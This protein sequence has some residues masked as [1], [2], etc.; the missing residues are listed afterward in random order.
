MCSRMWSQCLAKRRLVADVSTANASHHAP[1]AH[2]IAGSA[3][4][5]LD[6]VHLPAMTITT[7]L[8]R[9]FVALVDEVRAV[10]SSPGHIRVLG[11]PQPCAGTARDS[12]IVV[13]GAISAQTRL[14]ASPGVGDST[15]CS[16]ATSLGPRAHYTPQ[17]IFH[18][19]GTH[20]MVLQPQLQVVIL[21]APPP[22]VCAKAIDTADLLLADAQDAS[23]KILR[24]FNGNV[25]IM[26]LRGN[27]RGRS[28]MHANLTLFHCCKQMQQHPQSL[29]RTVPTMPDS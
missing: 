27:R 15:R 2:P 5:L 10:L 17:I 28:A 14:A 21:P 6:T 29:A 19:Q 3:G 4:A 18:P 13:Q 20:T 22:E 9:L 16:Q 11:R 23:K 8:C 7:H 26:L 25:E 1:S 24:G 12:K